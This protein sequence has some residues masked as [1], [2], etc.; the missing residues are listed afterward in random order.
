MGVKLGDNLE[1]RAYRKCIHD[2][3]IMLIVRACRPWLHSD[4][5]YKLF[6]YQQQLD[7]FL[8]PVHNFTKKVIKMRRN[9]FIDAQNNNMDFYQNNEN[10]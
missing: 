10:M 8:E 5:I 3:G 1:S 2:I 9:L 4:F 6:G 7:K